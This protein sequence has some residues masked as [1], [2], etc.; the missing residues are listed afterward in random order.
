MSVNP[1]ELGVEYS[2]SDMDVAANKLCT[3]I[4]NLTAE[5]QSFNMCTQDKH[6]QFSMMRCRV[7]YGHNLPCYLW[8][9]VNDGQRYY[10]I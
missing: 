10:D 8:V 2:T 6:Q 1:D 7:K 4:F 9:L 5:D 3:N